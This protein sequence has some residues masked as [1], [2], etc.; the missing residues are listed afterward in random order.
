[1]FLNYLSNSKWL[2]LCAFMLGPLIL[3][4]LSACLFVWQYNISFI[5]MAVSC[6]LRSG[7]KIFPALFF[8]VQNWFGQP[9][10]FVV[11]DEL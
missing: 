3:L 11:P 9:G 4:L 8:F 5:I 1:M 10:S 2:K 6:I 7:M